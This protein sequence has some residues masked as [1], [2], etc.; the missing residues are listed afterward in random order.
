MIKVREVEAKPGYRLDLQFSDGTMGMVDFTPFLA[1]RPFA[2][3]KNEAVFL[4]AYAENGVVTWPGDIDIAPEPLYALAH[5]LPAPGTL[6][7]AQA[8]ELAVSLRELRKITGKT[9][10]QIGEAMAMDQGQLSRLERRE[11][12]LL[13]TLRRY[14]EGLGGKLEVSA[15]FGDKRMTLRGV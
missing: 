15:V 5:D 10:A 7:Q 8:N 2:A 9:Q 1:E 14:V 12:H 13:S 6:E 4:E 11:D 3:L